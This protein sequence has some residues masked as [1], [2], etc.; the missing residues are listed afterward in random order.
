MKCKRC[1]TELRET[2]KIC[3]NCGA[4]VSTSTN[5]LYDDINKEDDDDVFTDEAEDE[6]YNKELED[7]L[8]SYQDK[9]KDDINEIPDYSTFDDFDV[10]RE[11]HNLGTNFNDNS[12]NN[13][14]NNFNNPSVSTGS[15]GLDDYKLDDVIELNDDKDDYVSYKK[16]KKKFQISVIPFKIIFII[17]AVVLVV[18][19]GLLIF[20]FVSS[21]KA[22]ET[23]YEINN[24]DKE[25]TSK[26]SLQSNPNYIT[27]KTWVCG[28]PLEDGS[29]TT[30]S[31][32]Y[33]QYDFNKDGT[34]ATQI[35]N[36]PDTYESGKYSVSLEDI[37][38]DQYT[39][40][41]TMTA[42]LNGGYKTRYTFTLI[43]NKEGT[44][45]TYKLNSNV[46]SCEEMN[47][48]NTKGK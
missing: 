5:D 14:N 21:K 2:D 13:Y 39:Y 9:N 31:S 29:L 47:Y 7:L 38:N 10:T 17:V 41:L 3:L 42:N 12:V 27:N 8:N 36:K 48:F 11:N 19:V 30:D 1:G 35:Y 4:L 26:Y 45:A 18:I 46:S 40:K 34:Y 16:E 15:T 24:G 22:T 33:F 6:S 28:T 32:S 23:E 43:T 25:N 20:K 44:K 37:S